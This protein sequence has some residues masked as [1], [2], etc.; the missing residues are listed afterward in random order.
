METRL[1]SEPDS[2]EDPL[3]PPSPSHHPP[4]SVTRAPSPPT[5]QATNPVHPT[6]RVLP[7]AATGGQPVLEEPPPEAPT[8]PGVGIAAAEEGGPREHPREEGGARGYPNSISQSL[9]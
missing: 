2:P 4:T 6:D 1:D 7:S 5:P 8:P 3:R 9:C